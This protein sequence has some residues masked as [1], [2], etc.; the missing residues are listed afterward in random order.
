MAAV[1]G[2]IF[3]ASGYSQHLG[4]VE[5]PESAMQPA[6]PKQPLSHEHTP[7][8]QIAYS[9]SSAPAITSRWISDVPS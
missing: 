9:F 5:A 8:H 1:T 4:L 7:L 6:H 3:T 2:G